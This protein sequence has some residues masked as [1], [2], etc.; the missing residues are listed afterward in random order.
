[1]NENHK[2]KIL[3]LLSDISENIEF[4]GNRGIA[5]DCNRCGSS[6]IDFHEEVKASK[7][8]LSIFSSYKGFI[9]AKKDI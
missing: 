6:D 4:L 5:A 1:M 2:A 7:E 9:Y 8:Q 3:E